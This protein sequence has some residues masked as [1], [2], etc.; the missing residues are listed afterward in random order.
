[1]RDGLIKNNFSSINGRIFAQALACASNINK[2][3]EP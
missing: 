1:M 2:A 3:A